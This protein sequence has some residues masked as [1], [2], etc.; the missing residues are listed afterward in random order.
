MR[1]MMQARVGR[2]ETQAN[3]GE[4]VI[5]VCYVNHWREDGTPPG[6]VTIPQ[7]G[8]KLSV[9]DF[10]RRYPKAKLITVEYVNDW[11]DVPV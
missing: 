6:I 3:T 10:A 1:R 8:E 11:G 7:T 2:L 4:Q 5:G 9:A